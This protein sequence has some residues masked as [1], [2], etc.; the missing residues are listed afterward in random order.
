MYHKGKYNHIDI[1]WPCML[2]EHTRSQ[3]LKIAISGN[4]SL[5]RKPSP[6]IF[7]IVSGSLVNYMTISVT[8]NSFGLILGRGSW[9]G[10]QSINCSQ[11]MGFSKQI[12]EIYESVQPVEL[13]FFPKASVEFLLGREPE[14]YRFLFYIAQNISRLGFQLACNSL[15]NLKGRIV[16][17]LLHLAECNV[18]SCSKEH[19]IHVTQHALS[20]IVGATRPRVNEELKELVEIGAIRLERGRITLLNPDFLQTKLTPI[21]HQYH[22]P[23]ICRSSDLI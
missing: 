7:Y 18:K 11:S 16:Y 1:E 13:L 19:V 3:L 5:L 4:E 23:K 6:G 10:V 8:S 17:A 14:L 21:D 20:Q 15:L 2:S 12:H 9:F 22:L